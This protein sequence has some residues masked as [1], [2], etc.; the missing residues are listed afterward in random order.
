[1]TSTTGRADILYPLDGELLPRNVFSPDVQ[2]STAGAAAGDVYRVRFTGAP[3]ELT[4][5]VLHSGA[6]FRYDYLVDY[7]AWQ[8]LTAIG[9]GQTLALTV[10]AQGRLLGRVDP[11]SLR[12]GLYLLEAVEK[13]ASLLRSGAV[14]DEA[15]LDK[16]SFTR[17]AYLQYRRASIFEIPEGLAIQG[18]TS[19]GDGRLP[20]LEPESPPGATP[21]QAP[22]LRA[23][24]SRAQPAQ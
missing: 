24:S 3:I 9:A 13:R 5:Y 23:P 15:A 18:E 4:A 8:R 17:D 12:H 11:D 2:W 7:P 10:D 21:P 6:G 1:S 20:E 22:P 19:P 16:Y 14:L